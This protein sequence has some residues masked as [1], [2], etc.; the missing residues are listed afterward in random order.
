MEK[1]LGHQD[2]GP[3][4]APQNRDSRTLRAADGTV[5]RNRRGRPAR[6]GFALGTLRAAAALLLSLPLV[7]AIPLRGPLLPAGIAKT[8]AAGP[9]AGD[10]ER[11]HTM[12]GD[13]L[14]PQPNALVGPND[15]VLCASCHTS[16][17]NGGSYPGTWTYAGSAH[18]SSPAMIWP[19]PDPTAR[20]ES[21]AAGKCLNCHD[22]HGWDDGLGR[23]PFLAV[24]REEKLC[25][26]CHSGSPASA[27]IRSDLLKP[28]R[29]PVADYTGRHAGP[30]ESQPADFAISPVNQ[31]HAECEDCH[32]PH[33][34][35]PD[36][37]TGVT[38]PDASK[39]LLGVSRVSVMNGAAGN[40]P[41]YTFLANSDTLT[42]PVSEYQLCFKCHSSWT[43]QP[44]GQTDLA[45]VLNPSNPSFH[46]VED[47]GANPTIA[48]SAF[49]SGWSASSL[50]GCGDCHGSD[51]GARGPHGSSYPHILKRPSPDSPT[52]R[53]MSS[54]ELCFSCHAYD[55]YANPGSPDATRLASRF[56]Q[57]G[58]GAG[59]AEHVGG[60]SVPCYA[61][62]ATHGSTT[63]P[64]LMVTGRSP[65]LVTYTESPGGGTCA[66]TCHSS[67]SYTANYA[68]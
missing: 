23:I 36:P 64:H 27:D 34:A 33:V 43:T 45:L 16:I 68:R 2:L 35:R 55:V 20:T 49:T 14:Q 7:S 67:Q 42:A 30:T 31:R 44:G 28:Y 53:S 15:N 6:R 40:A 62:H 61:C 11:C 26:A 8:L 58:T 17:W 38:P 41:S 48:P 1:G 51:L 29:H 56:N 21:G 22:P 13:D 66:P 52:P 59:H 12:H 50:T 24:A 37:P 65:G 46:P 54:D 18:G 10:C 19:G 32:N 47:R 63:L 25:L 5:L 9:H 39:R 4:V 60:Q 57:P 3:A